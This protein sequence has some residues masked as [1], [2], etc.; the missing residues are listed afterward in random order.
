MKVVAHPAAG[1]NCALALSIAEQH[2]GNILNNRLLQN[3]YVRICRSIL[4]YGSVVN[5]MALY[6]PL[7]LETMRVCS[8]N[9][10]VSVGKCLLIAI[11]CTLHFIE[12]EVAVLLY[13]LST[14]LQLLKPARKLPSEVKKTRVLAAR[15]QMMCLLSKVLVSVLDLALPLRLRRLRTHLRLALQLLQPQLTHFPTSRSVDL[16]PSSTRDSVSGYV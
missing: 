15:H 2:S 5:T 13:I 1:D 7:E 14:Q 10:S 9:Y 8:Q 6:A 12:A 4:Y 11:V 3:V 16:P